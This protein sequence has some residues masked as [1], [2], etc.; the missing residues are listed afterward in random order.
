VDPVLSLDNV[1]CISVQLDWT[2]LDWTRS[3]GGPGPIR[4]N[5]QVQLTSSIIIDYD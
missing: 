1:Q 2:G 5:D 3:N 4:S